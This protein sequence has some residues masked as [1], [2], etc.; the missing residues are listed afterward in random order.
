MER[1]TEHEGRYIKIKGRKTLYINKEVRTANSSNAIVRLAAYEDIG[2]DPKQV[3]EIFDKLRAIVEQLEFCE[4]ECK[5][6]P[7]T[8]NKAFICLKELAYSK[9]QKES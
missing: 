9:N 5:G 1:L 3:G 8:M 2:L 6:G 4:Y 7:L